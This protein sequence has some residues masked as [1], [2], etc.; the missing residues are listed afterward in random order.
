[1]TVRFSELHF[2]DHISQVSHNS[3]H[4]CPYSDHL[5]SGGKAT[6]ISD[7]NRS[8][9]SSVE[10]LKNNHKSGTPLLLLADDKYPLFPFDLSQKGITYVVLGWFM[11]TNCWG[12]AY[13]RFAK[14]ISPS[15]SGT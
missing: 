15:L 2:I 11:V 10:A 8:P 4:C 7:S 5:C 6:S 12:M 1:M 9:R 3:I 13:Y 14:P